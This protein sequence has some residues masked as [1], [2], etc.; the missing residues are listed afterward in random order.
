[1][2]ECDRFKKFGHTQFLTYLGNNSNKSYK[3]DG[4]VTNSYSQTPGKNKK[5]MFDPPKP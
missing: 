3:K 4:S 1:M 2:T 5:T